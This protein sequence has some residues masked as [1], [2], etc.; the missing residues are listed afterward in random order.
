MDSMSKAFS[1]LKVEKKGDRVAPPSHFLCP[2]TAS[3]M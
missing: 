1:R 2:I 3:L